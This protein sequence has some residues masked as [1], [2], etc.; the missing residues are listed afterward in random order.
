[1]IETP[2]RRRERRGAKGR[3]EERRERQDRD[4]EEKLFRRLARAYCRNQLEV[5]H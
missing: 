2:E 5:T 1:M 4:D 3:E